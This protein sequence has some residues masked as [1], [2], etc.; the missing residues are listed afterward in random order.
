MRA[1]PAG[2]LDERLAATAT[3]ATRL[4]DD[5]FGP[6]PQQT[7]T[8]ID[9]PWNSEWVGASYPGVVVTSRR[10]LALSRDAVAERILVAALARQ[11][12]RRVDRDSDP[13]FVEGLVLFSA[14]RAIHAVLGGRNFAT[15][16][17]FGGL[18]AFPVRAV[19]LS[20]NLA[21]R[22]PRVRDFDELFDPAAAPWRAAS[23]EAGS[24]A[25]LAAE[26]L[27][28]LERYIGWPALQQALAELARRGAATPARLAGIL[29][30]HRGIDMRWFFEATLDPAAQFD[31]AVENLASTPAGAESSVYRTEVSLR[32]LGPSVF[33]GTSRP[34]DTHT[35]PSLPV[36][37]RLADGTTVAAAIDGRDAESTLV[38]ESRSPA[39][40][41]T[42]DPAL[43]LLLDDHRINNSRRLDSTVN[44]TGVRL[45][46]H[47]FIWLQDVMLSSVSLL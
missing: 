27:A 28:T 5:W 25:R 16:P 37:V 17:A 46:L 9:A 21:Q 36:S 1:L 4:L 6:L 30:D 8:I 20:P 34:R 12:W 26:V 42:V 2:A 13:A 29:E 19:Q 14:A 43:M 3:D 47:W 40:A 11:Y 18:F 39:V 45:A 31:Y 10:W 32:R 22:G 38:F 23:V 33:A 15:V 35:A 44:A 7:P 24:A 41:A